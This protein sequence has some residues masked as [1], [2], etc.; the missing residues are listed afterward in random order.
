MQRAPGRLPLSRQA[1][2]LIDWIEFFAGERRQFRLA[3]PASLFQSK[4]K[5]NFN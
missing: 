3:G 1:A 4:L 2:Q 5:V